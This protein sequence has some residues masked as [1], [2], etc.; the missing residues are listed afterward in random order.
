MKSVSKNNN[1]DRNG[2]DNKVN[3]T[4]PQVNFQTKLANSKN[5]IRPDFLVKSKL[6]AKPSFRV[7]FL[8]FGAR[9]AFAKLR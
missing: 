7:D 3:R 2:G 9:L 1:V 5:K 6:L 8:A 4:K